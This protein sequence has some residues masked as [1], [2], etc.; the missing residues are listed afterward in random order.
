[1]VIGRTSG[2]PTAALTMPELQ[3]SRAL[4]RAMPAVAVLSHGR[5]YTSTV[6]SWRRRGEVCPQSAVTAATQGGRIA[7]SG[8]YDVT[9]TKF[10]TQMGPPSCSP[11]V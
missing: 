9:D 8:A 2:V 11:P 7:G 3:F 5:S 10:S 6:S 1:M 4:M